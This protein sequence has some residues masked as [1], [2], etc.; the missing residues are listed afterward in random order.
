MSDVLKGFVS[1]NFAYLTAWFLPSFVAAG[2]YLALVVPQLTALPVYRWFESQPAPFTTVT[3]AA[4]GVVL[5]V[6]LSTASTP[7]YRVF[8]G[9]SILPFK[10]RLRARM[11]R[12]RNRL[13]EQFRTAQEGGAGYAV[14]LILESMQKFPS[15]DNEVLPTRVGNAIRAFETYAWREYQ[16]DSQ[17]LWEPLWSV[18][19]Q[20]LRDD[21]DQARA[22]VDF[23][24]G[25]IVTLTLVGVATLVSVLGLWI[26]G[27]PVPLGLL[28]GGGV[29]PLLVTRCFYLLAVSASFTWGIAVKGIVNCGRV[30]MAAALGLQMPTSLEEERAM[31][32][33]VSRFVRESS[34]ESDW[35][36][37]DNFDRFRLGSTK[38]VTEPGASSQE[39]ATVK[40][41]RVADVVTSRYFEAVRRRWMHLRRR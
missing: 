1:G 32:R 33:L 9:Y 21:Y 8:E 23:C 38:A 5:G 30:P 37:A 29:A 27:K 18:T 26:I 10:A 34:P 40:D 35:E 17:S 28:L 14:N 19:P 3:I 15:A 39:D 2:A 20:Q 13:L 36:G 31:W 7:I 16:M 12:Q 4:S 25:T 6:V 41:A 24:V 11:L 22:G